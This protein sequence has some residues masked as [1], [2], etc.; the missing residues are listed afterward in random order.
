MQENTLGIYVANCLKSWGKTDIGFINLDA[1]MADLPQGTLTEGQLY[2][3][4]PFD[5]KVMFMK[6]RG[7]DLL[8]AL[9]ES[10]NNQ[11]HFYLK[12][13]EIFYSDTEKKKIGKIKVGG[14][15]IQNDK[16]YSLSLPDHI[17]S[18]GLGHDAFL[19]M[20]EFKNTDR[21]VREIVKWCLSRKVV[22]V[23]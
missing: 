15:N 6:M 13:L 23:K 16:L 18:G 2:K 11:K 14:Y 19:N 5:D 22:P 17:I 4:L 9:Q 20:F 1:L 12:G 7:D 3:A 21:P 8:Q 10:I